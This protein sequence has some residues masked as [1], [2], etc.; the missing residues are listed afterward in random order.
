MNLKGDFEE[1]QINGTRVKAGAGV[2]MPKLARACAKQG[3]S[4]VEALAGV[5]GTVGGG[6]MSNAGT[7][8]GSIGDVVEEVEVLK[9]DGKFVLLP[10]EKI[11]L[12]YRWSNLVGNWITSAVFRLHP[13]NNGSAMSAIKEEL[14]YRQKTQPLGTKN[15]GS[16]FCN[17][18]NQHAAKLIEEVGLKGHRHGRLRFSPKHANFIE[19]LGGGTAK[20]ALEL[21]RLAQKL[22]KKE[23]DIDLS[24]EVKF[25]KLPEMEK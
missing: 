17:P 21:I 6:L 12:R 16:V 4:G 2:Q 18:P 14:E 1:I 15:V 19:N 9:P 5:P 20:E 3:L 23:F 10:K 22:V 25:I 13:A 8:R 11:T 24:P 7:R